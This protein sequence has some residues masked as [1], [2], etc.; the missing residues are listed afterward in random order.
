MNLFSS[1]CARVEKLSA[2]L[3]ASAAV[4]GGHFHGVHQCHVRKPDIAVSQAVFYV[5]VA[6]GLATN[7]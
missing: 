4:D 1:K 5:A 6:V 3:A 7:H 2:L